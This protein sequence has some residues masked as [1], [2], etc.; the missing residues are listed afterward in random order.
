MKT[1]YQTNPDEIKEAIYQRISDTKSFRYLFY[2]IVFGRTND[3]G[4]LVPVEQWRKY[5]DKREVSKTNRLIINL[6]RECF[7]VKEEPIK[8]FSFRER[9]N[10][11]LDEYRDEIKKG[12][13][14][15]HLISTAVPDN[16]IQ[17][18]NR[19]L[20]SLI[21]ESE[22]ITNALD[23]LQLLSACT[24]QADWVNN[25]PSAIVIKSI[26]SPEDLRTVTYYCLKTF[27][28]NGDIDFTDIIDFD[29]SDYKQINK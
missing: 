19:K 16:A 26:N 21:R 29:N 18:P 23:P 22:T 1:T 14:H 25:D 27:T 28:G 6:I 8:F 4:N 7:S 11:D 3:T 13:Y 20:K 15:L 12:R 5:W 24:R 9:H 17:I 10:P 2:T